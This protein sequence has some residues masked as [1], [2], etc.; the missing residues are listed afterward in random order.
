[1]GF[2]DEHRT[3]RERFNSLWEAQHPDV[4]ITWGNVGFNPDNHTSW[5]RLTIQDGEARQVSMGFP[6]LFR[7]TGVIFVQVFTPSGV[8]P[9]P[10]LKLADDAA[11]IFRNFK[12]DGVTCRAPSIRD[13]RQ[14]GRW[15]QV[16]LQVPFYR[17][18]M[19]AV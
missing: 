1:M 4:R 10:A 9:D 3:I 6:K 2:A 12:Q 11:A 15:Y 8:G 5:V 7:N 19:I 17:D 13:S 14:D 16:V 18:E